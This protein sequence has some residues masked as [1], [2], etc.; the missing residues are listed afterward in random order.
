MNCYTLFIRVSIR[1]YKMMLPEEKL[2]MIE[3][4]FGVIPEDHDETDYRAIDIANKRWMSLC[5]SKKMA[6]K[7][8]ASLLNLRPKNGQFERLPRNLQLN[9]DTYVRE[10]LIL[11]SEKLTKKFVRMMVGNVNLRRTRRTVKMPHTILLDKMVYREISVSTLVLDTVFGRNLEKFSPEELVSVKKT[12]KSAMTYHVLSSSRLIDI[13]RVSDLNFASTYMHE[14]EYTFYLCPMGAVKENSSDIIHTGYFFDERGN[15]VEFR[16]PISSNGQM[17]ST[18]LPRP[19]LMDS[20]K[21]SLGYKTENSR[22]NEFFLKE[23]NPVCIYIARRNLMNLKI[24]SA[25]VCMSKNC[26]LVK[27]KSS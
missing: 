3:M 2:E 21:P 11:D 17:A 1:E 12:K 16:Y 20:D 4:N 13:L 25:R 7:Y 10:S 19:I 22:N 8:R 9:L 23:F 14:D 15:E 27:S 26:M 6:W 5:R 24:C 18:W